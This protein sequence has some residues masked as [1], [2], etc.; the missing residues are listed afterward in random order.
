MK[1]VASL[2]DRIKQAVA[3]IDFSSMNQKEVEQLAKMLKVN[4]VWLLG[5]DVPKKG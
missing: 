5:Y 2:N 3:E 1:Q 4:F